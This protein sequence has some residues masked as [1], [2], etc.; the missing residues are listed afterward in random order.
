MDVKESRQGDVVILRPIG[1]IDTRSAFEF[2][3]RLRELLEEGARLMVVD[4]DKVD[5]LT[6]AGIRV[7]L[8]VAKKLKGLDGELVLCSLDEHLRTV[9]EISGLL[10]QFAILASPVEAISRLSTGSPANERMSKVSSLA[11]RLLSGGAASGHGKP[12]SEAGGPGSALS[13]EVMDLL[14]RSSGDAP[15]G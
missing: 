2:E 5:Q 12:R 6:S 11:I 15:E 10:E 13:R 1:T 14:S 9:L 7:L 4:F 3:A 8:M